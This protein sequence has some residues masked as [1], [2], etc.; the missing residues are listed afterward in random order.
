MKVLILN[1]TD[2]IGGAARAA[3][4]IH[5]G[6][7]SQGI[8]SLMLVQTKAGDDPTVIGPTRKRSKAF[9][10]LRPHLDS[11]PL[12]FYRNR[13]SSEWSVGWLPKKLIEQ[14]TL[15]NPDII[16]LHWINGGFIPVAMLKKLN[17][18]VAWTLHDCWAFTGGCHYPYDCISYQKRCGS[19]PQLL[20]NHELD[21]SRWVWNQK[22]K[23]LRNLNITAVANCRWMAECVK[24][25]SLLQEA[26]IEL[27]PNCVDASKFKPI[28]KRAAREILNLPLDKNLVLFGVKNFSQKRKGFHLL[29]SALEKLSAG[30]LHEN[31][32][33]V[34]FGSLKSDETTRLNFPMHTLGYVHDDYSLALLYSACDVLMVPSIQE[35]SS[36]TVYEAMACGTPALSFSIG[37]LPD[38]ID[39]KQNGYLARPFDTE[40]LARGITWIVADPDRHAA[41]CRAAR[42][43]A[44]REYSYSVVAKKYINLF[45]ELISLP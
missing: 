23:H 6:L 30:G 27:I 28:K 1:S 14:I 19:C 12:Q 22:A 4:S 37:G 5:K 9:N 32:E 38:L 43:K 41:L 10:Q 16:N 3:Y 44:E 29:S 21:L 18:P 13:L 17:K 2:I 26:R 7:Q 31:M 40:D 11:L 25:S 20:S 36:L 42:T 15:L 39:H 8:N 45:S 34:V 35:N 24:S 33:L